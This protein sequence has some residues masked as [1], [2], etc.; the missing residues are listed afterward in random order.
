MGQVE[1]GELKAMAIKYMWF[2]RCLEL[3]IGR[4]VYYSQ[5]LVLAYLVIRSAR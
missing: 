3:S 4:L 2:S 5:L 1:K